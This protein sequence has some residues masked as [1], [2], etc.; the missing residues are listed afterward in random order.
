MAKILSTSTDEY[1]DV[2]APNK[3]EAVKLVGRRGV[4][5][6]VSARSYGAIWGVY[7]FKRK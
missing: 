6:E 4:F 1:I 5:K 2:A 3:K 7:I